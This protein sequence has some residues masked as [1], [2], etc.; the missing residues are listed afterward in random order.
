MVE[1]LDGLELWTASAIAGEFSF[2]VKRKKNSPLYQ[3]LMKFQS[4]AKNPS[5]LVF[6]F[7]GTPTDE[8]ERESFDLATCDWDDS[9]SR[10][11][12]YHLENDDKTRHWWHLLTNEEQV[13]LNEE[14]KRICETHYEMSEGDR[15]DPLNIEFRYGFNPAWE[16]YKV[17]IAKRP[18]VETLEVIEHGLV[19]TNFIC[20]CR[21]TLADNETCIQGTGD[22][23]GEAIIYI[24]D[25]LR[26]AENVVTPC[27][28]Y[29]DLSNRLRSHFGNRAEPA[30]GDQYWS[31]MLEDKPSGVAKTMKEAGI[32]KEP[33][34]PSREDYSSDE[35]FE[36]AFQEFEERSDAWNEAEDWPDYVYLLCL[37]FRVAGEHD[38]AAHDQT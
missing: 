28:D 15:E 18:K 6:L 31:W 27:I 36:V 32:V 21:N 3:K 37:K 2:G 13:F 33:N 12:D 23:P 38:S 1:M 26:N 22:T 24:L 16:N 19:E 14:Y 34:E 4:N 29:F 35:E 11:S 5:R 8:S 9:W 25:R 10:R 30:Y 20:S 17:E 7:G